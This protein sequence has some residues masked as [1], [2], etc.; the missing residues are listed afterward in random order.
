MLHVT[1]NVVTS[2]TPV[3]SPSHHVNETVTW[4]AGG[5]MPANA[6][7]VGPM[8]ELTRQAVSA[9][10]VNLKTSGARVN[11]VVVSIHRR[12]K[13]T[14]TTASNVFPIPITADAETIVKIPAA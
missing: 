3:A 9:T 14:P 6:T 2:S 8:P 12:T 1:S 10:A 13:N 11:G 5:V 4:P 7:T